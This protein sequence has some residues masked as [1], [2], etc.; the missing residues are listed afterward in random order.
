[1][2]AIVIIYQNC[3]SHHFPLVP[4]FYLLLKPGRLFQT[5]NFTLNYDKV[6]PLKLSK[7]LISLTV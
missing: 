2:D 7:Y 4:A 6:F 1:M 3:S 5:D